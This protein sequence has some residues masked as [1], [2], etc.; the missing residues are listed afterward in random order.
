MK[1]FGLIGYP[2]KHSF[3]AAM[4]NAAF[5]ELGIDAR[6]ELFEVRPEELHQDFKRLLAE[7]ICGFNVTIPHKEGIVGSLDEIHPEAELIGAV[8]TIKVDQDKTTKG[9]NTDGQGFITHLVQVIGFNPGGKRVAILG[10]G[11]AA[12]AVSVQLAKSEAKSIL[13]FDLDQAKAKGLAAKLKDNFSTCDIRLVSEADALLKNQPELLVNATP[14]G[15][16]KDDKLIFNPEYLHPRLIVYDLIYNPAETLLLQEAK[17][18]G[19]RGVFNGLGM[20]LYQ[21][22]LAFEI[23]L[24]IEP[25][26]EIMERALREALDKKVP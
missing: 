15:M 25:P 26:I 21:G 11:G 22:V 8:N 17:R 4:H 24:D 2:V 23:W 10:A 3:S 5:K 19:C 18:K 14:V 7:G 9:F 12:K 13:L 1:R 16:Y 6:Y 20:L